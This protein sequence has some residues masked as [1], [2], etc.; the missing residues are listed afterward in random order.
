MDLRFY[1][2]PP[3]GN[4]NDGNQSLYNLPSSG[5]I[6]FV[7][8]IKR[9]LLLNVIFI[10]WGFK[11]KK[12]INIVCFKTLILIKCYFLNILSLFVLLWNLSKKIIL[13][14]PIRDA[15]PFLSRSILFLRPLLL[16]GKC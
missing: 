5:L 6:V 15:P 10:L 7:N 9:I 2:R 1:F 12:K 14:R 3:S 11:I 4:F 16:L 8:V 13:F